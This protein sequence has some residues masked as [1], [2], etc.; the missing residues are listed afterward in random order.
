M[1]NFIIDDSVPQKER[2]EISESVLKKLD[3]MKHEISNRIP[4]INKRRDFFEGDHTKWTNVV[5][6][7][8]KKQE[9]HIFYP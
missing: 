8:S 9:G 1:P 5:G 4:V 7:A 2:E 6:Q 3:G